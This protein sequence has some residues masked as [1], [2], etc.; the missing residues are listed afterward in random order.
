MP[1]TETQN[2]TGKVMME[3]SAKE[4]NLIKRLRMLA[5]GKVMI[6]Q[7]GSQPVRIEEIRENIKL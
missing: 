5:F 7:E 3:L 4:A 1:K 2:V 6:H